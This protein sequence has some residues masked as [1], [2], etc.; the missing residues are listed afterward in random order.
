MLH[1][2]IIPSSAPPVHDDS[3]PCHPSPCGPNANCRVFESRPVCSC[4]ANYIGRPPSCRPE[5]TVNSEC[6]SNKACINERCRDPC[7]GSCGFNA[8]CYVHAHTPRCGCS[9]GYTGDPFSGCNKIVPRKILNLFTQPTSHSNLVKLTV[10]EAPTNPCNPSPCGAN[11]I[12][13]ERNG[14]GSCACVPEYFGDPYIECRPECVMNSDCPKSRACRN[15]KCIDPC[16]GTCGD[17]A[18][19]QVVNHNPTCYCINDYIGDPFIR[20]NPP[21]SKTKQISSLFFYPT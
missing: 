13:K 10:I 19:C 5:C 8:E 1:T 11:A 18:L 12:C 3:N 9:D 16:P 15:N 20:C 2:K 21:P 17:N 14:A 7:P 4:I 6:P